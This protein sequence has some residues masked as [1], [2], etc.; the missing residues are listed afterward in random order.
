MT[1]LAD[2]LTEVAERLRRVTVRVRSRGSGEASGVIWARAGYIVTNAHVARRHATVV[3]ADGRA[4][5]A[6][7]VAWDPSR[8]LAAL[9]VEDQG[10][11]GADVRDSAGVRV[12]ELVLGVGNPLG[13]RGAVSTGVIHAAGGDR[14]IRADLRLAPGNSG[15]PLADA[16]GRVIGINAMVAGGLALAVPSNTV[17]RFLANLP[18]AR[19]EAR[20]S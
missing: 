7:V 8:D 5:E 14:W 6:P 1:S 18:R 3:L 17:A 10:L 12:G 19:Q 20:A 9:A 16:H 15:G 13:L 11:P 2:A 4:F